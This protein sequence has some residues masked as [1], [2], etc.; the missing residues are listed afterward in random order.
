MNDGQIVLSHVW[1]SMPMSL[2]SQSSALRE[3][4]PNGTR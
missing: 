4:E 2:L 3:T 1:T